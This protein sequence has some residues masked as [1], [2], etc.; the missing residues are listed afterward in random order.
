MS[1]VQ[2]LLLPMKIAFYFR[3]VPGGIKTH[4]DMLVKHIQSFGHETKIIDQNTLGSHMLGDFYG[5]ENG[6]KR[7]KEEISDCDILHI[8]HGATFSEFV[9]PF[10]SIKTPIT[11][12]FHIPIGDSLQGILTSSVIR[13]LARLYS[14]RSKAYI[15]VSHNVASKLERYNK[16]VT[17][18]NGVD[19]DLFH[20]T[21]HG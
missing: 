6:V 19:I 15:S 18:P 8:H 17:I 2:I 11:N 4:V 13:L 5:F 12:T 21:N 1:N 20:P 9:I 10:Y 3:N 7:I 16:T 14:K